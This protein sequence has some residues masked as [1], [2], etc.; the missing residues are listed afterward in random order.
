MRPRP[1]LIIVL[2]TAIDGFRNEWP[3]AFAGPRIDELSGHAIRWSTTQNRRSRG[4]IPAGCFIDGRPTIVLRDPFLDWFESFLAA[5][6][7]GS[8]PAPRR[9]RQTGAAKLTPPRRRRSVKPTPQ[10]VEPAASA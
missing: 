8:C 4:E 9:G 7:P 1:A 10:A 6:A 2:L 5:R 3:A